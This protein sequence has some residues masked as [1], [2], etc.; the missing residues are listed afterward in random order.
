MRSWQAATK[1]M[2]RMHPDKG[3]KAG[4]KMSTRCAK[5]T[6]VKDAIEAAA[7]K[8]NSDVEETS[9]DEDD[10]ISNRRSAAIGADPRVYE[11]STLVQTD[12][13]NNYIVLC[14]RVSQH[15]VTP[16]AKHPG[17]EIAIMNQDTHAKHVCQRM[18]ASGIEHTS[19]SECPSL[20]ILGCHPSIFAV[21]HVD[22]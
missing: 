20:A 21:D 16:S 22:N 12:I 18:P 9:E 10:E 5:L 3:H 14:I 15:V 11:V 4:C 2:V 1:Q 7:T 13:A 8:G 6:A 19:S 17:Y